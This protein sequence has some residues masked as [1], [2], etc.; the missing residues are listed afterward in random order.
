MRP[1]KT[2]DGEVMKPIKTDIE[3]VMRPIKTDI[4]EVMRPI[5]TDIR[6]VPSSLV[7]STSHYSVEGESSSDGGSKGYEVSSL[8]ESNVSYLHFLCWHFYLM[9]SSYYYN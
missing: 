6:E 3:E 4:G 5:K 7:L 2:D 9:I 8:Q 1:I